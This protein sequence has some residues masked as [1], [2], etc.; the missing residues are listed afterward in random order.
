MQWRHY[1]TQQYTTEVCRYCSMTIII[2][3]T[4]LV[5]AIGDGYTWKALLYCLYLVIETLCKKVEPKPHDQQ[6]K[7]SVGRYIQYSWSKSGSEVLMF[8]SCSKLFCRKTPLATLHTVYC[9]SLRSKPAPF[10]FTV[11]VAFITLLYTA[12]NAHFFRSAPPYSSEC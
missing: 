8:H 11:H 6:I 1:S 5:G 12:T 7:L 10:T 3:C 4:M 2:E 9:I